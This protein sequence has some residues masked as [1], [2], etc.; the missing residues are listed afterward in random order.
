M[1][2]VALKGTECVLD[3]G[4]MDGTLTAQLAELAAQGEAVGIGVPG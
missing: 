2:E 1:V 3:L 4:F